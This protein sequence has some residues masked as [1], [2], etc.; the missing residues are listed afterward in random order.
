MPPKICW[1]LIPGCFFH[2]G[3][4]TQQV[5]GFMLT[6]SV[7]KCLSSS[8][9]EHQQQTALKTTPKHMSHGQN[10]LYKGEQRNVKDLIQSLYDPLSLGFFA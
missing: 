4:G 5:R 8:S 1:Y 2:K 10:S 6:G 3:L 9:Q 7:W